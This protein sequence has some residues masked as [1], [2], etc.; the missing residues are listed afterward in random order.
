V[1]INVVTITD[2]MADFAGFN[3]LAEGA[4]GGE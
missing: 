2:M 1:I 4:N 3:E